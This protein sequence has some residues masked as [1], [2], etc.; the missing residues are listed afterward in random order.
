MKKVILIPVF[1]AVALMFQSFK[2]TVNTN[3]E[4]SVNGKSYFID[5]ADLQ[6]DQFGNIM[7]DSQIQTYNGASKVSSTGH[8]VL[9]PG[10]GV[11]CSGVIMQTDGGVLAYTGYKAKGHN[12][13]EYQP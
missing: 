7:D 10:S 11:K 3:V 4:I 13:I 1:F 8:L 2:S 5:K 12:D 9:C 6:L